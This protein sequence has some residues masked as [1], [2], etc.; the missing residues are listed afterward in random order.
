MNPLWKEIGSG[1][2]A[3]ALRG[4]LTEV[5]GIGGIVTYAPPVDVVKR[6]NSL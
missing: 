2:E 5:E 1:Q 3:Y 6:V 4:N